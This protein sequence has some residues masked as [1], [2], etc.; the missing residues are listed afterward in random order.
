MEQT[1]VRLFEAAAPTFSTATGRFLSA[2]RARN[3][4]PRTQDYY[5]YRLAAFARF[6]AQDV[7][8]AK[9]SPAQIRDFLTSEIE[10][11]SAGTAAHSYIALSAFFAHLVREELLDSNPMRLIVK[12]KRRRTVI[13]TFSTAQAK[14][15]IDTCGRDWYGVRDRAILLTLLDT[16]LRA[17]ECCGLALADVSLEDQT[18]R[19]TGKGD[20]ERVVPFGESV[21][22]A[23]G[24]YLAR[25]SGVSS[26]AL[27][28]N[29]YGEQLTRYGLRGMVVRRSRAAGITGVRL[30]PHTLR[31]TCAVFYLRAGGDAF[32]LQKLLGHEDLTMTRRYCELADS[33]VRDQHR[34]HSPADAL[35]PKAKTGRRRLR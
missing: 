25:R 18:F 11:H 14:S 28:T 4:S 30:S 29:H 6:A 9:I 24:C 2:C 22:S 21:R 7:E 3:L 19:V 27:F 5:R 17:S 8:V 10:R 32:S 35:A 13:Q 23:L 34:L 12:P 1:A 15:L 31:H 33:D 16:G 26:A 20:R